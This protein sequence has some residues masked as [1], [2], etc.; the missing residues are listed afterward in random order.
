V[1][2]IILSATTGGGHMSA[3]NA[4][5]N[6]LSDF[7][8]DVIVLDTIEY[9]NPILNKTITEGYEYLAKK[10]PSIYKV[11]YKT[12]N[13]EKIMKAITKVNSLISKKLIPLMNEYNPDVI[14][15]THPFS[16]EMVSRL[17]GS[18]KINAPIVCIMTDY[19]PH[20]TWINDNVDAYVVANDEMIKSMY[21][22]GVPYWKVY[23]YGIPIDEGFYERKD[24]KIVLREMGLNPNLPTLLIMAGSFG[25]KN[26]LEIYKEILEICIDFQIIVITGRNEQLYD[27]IDRV[28]HGEKEKKETAFETVCRFGYLLKLSFS[29]LYG[30]NKNE[31]IS[32]SKKFRDIH[33]K[34]TRIIYFTKEVDKYMQAADLIIT[35][36]GGL[37]ITEALACNIPM[38]IFDAIPGQEDE[39][40]D[41]LVNKNMAIRLEKGEKGA[42]AVKELL[43]CGGKLELMK[44]SCRTFDKSD[45]LRKI[46]LLLERI[47][48]N[49]HTEI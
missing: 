20:R 15:T 47:C 48:K 3:A 45:S 44:L 32:G 8:S 13:K 26:I 18:G 4:I 33:K 40:A 7:A 46:R 39:N 43:E 41:F 19:A 30:K 10:R 28:V 37:T 34:N 14:I 5:K 6:Y 16:T 11:M 36:P 22:M 31:N 2:I 23:P 35:K 25:V 12:A 17:K 49:L 21:S 42:A 1:K 9:I 29:K 24:K 27:S 38:A